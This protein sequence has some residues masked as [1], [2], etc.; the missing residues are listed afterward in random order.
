VAESAANPAIESV[1][2]TRHPGIT[3]VSRHWRN[4]SNSLQLFR[5]RA[6]WRVDDDVLVMPR[7]LNSLFRLQ[8]RTAGYAGWSSPAH[9]DLSPIVPCLQ[10]SRCLKA[11]YTKRLKP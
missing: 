7:I 5:S 4:L 1:L 11:N 10:M 3:S 8:L 9:S 2:L 6:S